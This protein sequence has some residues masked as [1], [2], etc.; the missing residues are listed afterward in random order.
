MFCF[1]QM[2]ILSIPISTQE[3]Q[4]CESCEVKFEVYYIYLLL[5]ICIIKKRKKSKSYTVSTFTRICAVAMSVIFGSS[6]KDGALGI[7]QT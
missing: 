7:C 4:V 3:P 2:F 6:I 5:N 1:L